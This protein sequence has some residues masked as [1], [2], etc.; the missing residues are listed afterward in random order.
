[1]LNI[2]GEFTISNEDFN[3][4]ENSF[5]IQHDFTDIMSAPFSFTKKMVDGNF[6]EFVPMAVEF[7]DLYIKAYFGSLVLAPTDI[8]SY[9]FSVSA[10]E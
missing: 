7:S 9:Q 10:G 4:F 6:E 1:M 5:L 8:I 2:G 3:V